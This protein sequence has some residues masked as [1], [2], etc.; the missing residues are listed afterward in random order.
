M[1]SIPKFPKK[2]QAYKRK[3]PAP[4]WP[5]RAALAREY[6]DFKSRNKKNFNKSE[7]RKLRAIHKKL[8][9]VATRHDFKFIRTRDRKKLKSLSGPKTSKGIFV[10]R[11]KGE[12]ITLRNAYWLSD[13]RAETRYVLKISKEE[14]ARIL[15]KET[16]DESVL[17]RAL[18]R[19]F[20]GV[21]VRID[22]MRA[23]GFDVF[24]SV[25]F[26]HAGRPV[27]KMSSWALLEDYLNEKL[28]EKSNITGIII[29]ID[30]E[31]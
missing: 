18:V 20:R 9:Y 15:S 6:T 23:L 8:Q 29:T 19:R 1:P 30:K 13:S 14:L 2:K 10:P 21:F 26:D 24:F 12:K 25:E 22:T 11:K 3:K 31:M 7:K 27:R 17:R 28:S 5:A 4:D 16:I